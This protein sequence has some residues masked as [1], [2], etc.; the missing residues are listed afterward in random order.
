MLFPDIRWRR[1]ARISSSLAG[2]RASADSRS[3]RFFA[4]TPQVKQSLQT[5]RQHMRA[6][7]PSAVEKGKTNVNAKSK[8]KGT[9]GG[10]GSD[11]AKDVGQD[12]AEE[13]GAAAGHELAY[14]LTFKLDL[15]K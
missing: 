4:N 3:R 14:F 10:A 9:G 11:T 12:S 8:R 5:G 6:G 15:I 13:N 1:E 2:W 7:T